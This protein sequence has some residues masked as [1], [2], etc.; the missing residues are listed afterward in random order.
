MGQELTKKLKSMDWKVSGNWEKSDLTVVSQPPAVVKEVGRLPGADFV[1]ARSLFSDSLEACAYQV[2][3]C[4]CACC[5]RSSVLPDEEANNLRL[6]VARATL[7]AL[8]TRR[9][10]VVLALQAIFTL[11]TVIGLPY[12]AW[13]MMTCSTGY[14]TYIHGAWVGACL[15]SNFICDMLIFLQVAWLGP[16][17]FASFWRFIPAKDVLRFVYP[18]VRQY[19][20]DVKDNTRIGL[21]LEDFLLRFRLPLLLRFG[22]TFI[23]V[24]DLYQDATFPVIAGT[25]G[26]D[27]WFVSAWLVFL[28]VGVMQILVQLMLVMSCWRAYRNARTPED[29]ERDHIQ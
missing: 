20:R 19:S 22:F 10:A 8:M 29:W 23:S 7:R 2:L 5:T 26:F 27:L 1:E 14:P 16:F 24:T 15:G 25:C 9:A 3:A 18:V 28:G 21:E 11:G 12:A 13:W 6:R 4:C 17:C